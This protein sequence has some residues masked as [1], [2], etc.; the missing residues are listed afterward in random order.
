MNGRLYDPKLHR[1]LQPDNYVQDPYNSQNFN[2]YGY[3]YNN[4]L[5]HVDP[6]GEFIHLIVGAV[7][8]GVI[9]WAANGAK[10]S[11]K[12]L[13]H[14]GVGALSGA[15]GAGVGAGVSSALGGGTFGAGFLGTSAAK[16]V[17]SGFLS[18]A[19]VGGS[20]GFAGGFTGG[21]GNALVNGSS[22]SSALGAGFKGGAMGALGG[23]L[24][25]GTVSGLDAMGDGRN[26]WTGAG[27]SRHEMLLSGTGNS[28]QYTS[29]EDMWADYNSNIGSRDGMSLSQVEAKLNTNVS[30]A[31]GNLKGYSINGDGL[32]VNSKGGTVGGVTIGEYTGGIKNRLLSTRVLISPGVKGYDL[33]ARNMVFKHEFMHVW[34]HNTNP[35][36]FDRFSERAASTYSYAYTKAYPSLNWMMSSYAYMELLIK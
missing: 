16:A 9:N 34:H 23:S 25:G 15:L 19:V 36:Y 21:F 3:V 24:I 6:S 26:F 5:S 27:E 33:L 14:F 35:A 4:P 11:W 10:F 30:L 20:G 32:L 1:F 29:N 17:G 13:A 18:G 8:G 12:G 2:R 28:N 7:I 31:D 22:F